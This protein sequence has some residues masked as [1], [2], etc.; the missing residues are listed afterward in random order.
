[1][2]QAFTPL[3]ML[4]LMLTLS[5]QGK[6][7]GYWERGSEIVTEI[8]PGVK[9]LLQNP[10]SSSP[11]YLSGTT[12]TA[13]PSD[14]AIY[15]F[16][17]AGVSSEQYQLYR[18]KQAFTGEYLEDPDYSGGK[19]TMTKSVSRAFVFTALPGE[20]VVATT[21]V[22]G[23]TVA[24]Q[25]W[26]DANPRTKYEPMEQSF[27]NV[28]VFC[29][30]TLNT[31]FQV[32]EIYQGGINCTWYQYSNARIW[33]IYEATK[34][35]AFDDLSNIIEDLFH[36]ADASNAFVTGTAPGQVPEKYTK[37]LV[38]A[39]NA[40]IQL[41]SEQDDKE[42]QVYI[43]AK[44]R[45]SKAYKACVD[46]FVYVTEGFYF[47]DNNP[48]GDRPAYGGGDNAYMKDNNGN[49]HWA[50]YT[51][52]EVMTLDGTFFM[53]EVIAAENGGWYL[54][55]VG[56]NRYAGGL[57]NTNVV[58]PSTTTASQLYNI[59]H[60]KSDLFA[61]NLVGQNEQ[62]PALHADKNPD[63]RI[64][65]WETQADA[66]L[67]KFIPVSETDLENV[68]HELEQRRLNEAMLSLH[69]KAVEDYNN[70][71]SY[72][73]EGCTRDGIFSM[74]HNL[75]TSA[76]QMVSNAMELPENEPGNSYANLIDGVFTTYF[77]TVWSNPAYASSFHYLDL[78]LNEPVKT[79]NIKYA[80]RHNNKAGSPTK[81]HVYAS[82]DTTN[83]NWISQGYMNCKYP[84]S[85][86]WKDGEEQEV[87][88][89][90]YAGIASLDMKDA[91]KYIRL[92][93]E[94]TWANGKTNNNLFWY[95]SELRLY[96]SAYDPTISLIE[97][98]PAELRQQLL[99]VLAT[100]KSELDAGKATQKTYDALK[101]TYDKFLE[102]FPKPQ[103]LRDLINEAQEQADNAQEGE[104]LGY[105]APNAAQALKNVIE[106]V[107]GAVKDVMTTD[108]INDL[109]SKLEVALANFNSKLIMPADGIFCYLK[110]ATSSNAKGSAANNYLYAINNDVSQVKYGLP[111]VTT[112][113]L[114]YLWKVVK[115]D[116]GSF[117]FMNA[118]TGTYIGN[119]K[120]NNKF[121]LMSLDKDSVSLRSAKAPGQFNFVCAE[122]VFYNAQ[123]G[124][125]N[126]VTWNTANG[127]DNSAFI[128]EPIE[129]M[130]SP[131][132]RMSVYIELESNE[133][134]I[135]SYPFS[136]NGEAANSTLY[137]VLGLKDDFLELEA[138]TYDDIIPEAT[139]FI[140]IPNAGEEL[141]SITIY[142]GTELSNKD[143]NFKYVFENQEQNGMIAT[144]R[145]EKD[146]IGGGILFDNNV[147]SA[148]E[149]DVSAANS[150]YF[151]KMPEE[152]TQSGTYQMT[153][154][155]SITT[156]VQ[157]VIIIPQQNSAVYTVTGI[158]VR[159]NANTKNLPRGIY[160]IG[161]KKM[162]VK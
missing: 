109:K 43:D 121:V 39:Y 59:D 27:E 23:K 18:L 81:I 87:T 47:I 25:E 36:G 10:W 104:D 117:S 29:N 119:P 157:D 153:F 77:H 97:A 107:K 162:F 114:H 156:G 17:E 24:T 71:F 101:A 149:G 148:V 91:Y 41:L 85:V 65:V 161:G 31:E 3:V 95:W 128:I 15:V 132:D 113:K 120:E 145:A 160:I 118:A 54:R 140:M 83:G 32:F 116:D 48:N 159:N 123:P 7:Q 19:V 98:V 134:K 57:K 44:E 63:K 94:G 127:S 138:Y 5:L 89:D 4:F 139:P 61:L 13:N 143:L 125:N 88:R 155:T 68:N 92:S 102:K 22:D 141:N 151:Y 100:S 126:L 137:K 51:K 86:K 93:V 136:I 99:D 38:E 130:N 40:V 37:E 56:T 105:F 8:K 30:K 16:E 6:A 106:S 11:H 147:I 58:V 96:K 66:S 9:Y 73:A 72:T 49:L 26:I 122:N 133:A 84:Y 152:T 52:P 79:F 35:S 64:V 46:N 14:E 80:C 45:L 129:K 33:H 82:N 110:S 28:F 108:E 67:W 144:L 142:L 21:V 158:K 90:N 76:D 1:M 103:I 124:T 53:W 34:L 75:I 60:I 131:W 150:G 69:N 2:K 55:N 12:A 70:G 42:P 78:R 50:H 111:K 20:P 115:N 135:M 62:F 154:P 112:D 74:E 146:I